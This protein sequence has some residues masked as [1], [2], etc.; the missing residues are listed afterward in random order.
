LKGRKEG[1]TKEPGGRRSGGR[2]EDEDTTWMQAYHNPE[3]THTIHPRHPPLAAT[4]I[5]LQSESFCSIHTDNTHPLDFRHSIA[6]FA[7][8]QHSI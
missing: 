2:K 5:S 4:I 7:P 1:G 8:R 3:T 6:A